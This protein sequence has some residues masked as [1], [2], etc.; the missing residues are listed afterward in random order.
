SWDLNDWIARGCKVDPD[1]VAISYIADGNPDSAPFCMTYRELRGH[2]LAAANLFHALGVSPSDTV[3]FVLPTVPQLYVGM[4]GAV[5][6]GIACS[7]NWMLKPQQL[8][9]LVR[10]ASAKVLVVL[11]PTP[12]Y[13]IWE[14]VQA[15]R[16]EIAASV[17]ILTV[18]GPGGAI[19]PETDFDTHVAR[20][21]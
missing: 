13:D 15:I 20:H 8:A 7:V 4:L 19:D 18:P 17:R 21:A 14:N 12:G 6:A 16:S 1:K 9:E 10:A 11:G 3:M 2:S 5:A